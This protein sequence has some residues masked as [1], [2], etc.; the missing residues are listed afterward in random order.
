MITRGETKEKG[1]NIESNNKNMS[2]ENEQVDTSVEEIQIST[3][4]QINNLIGGLEESSKLFNTQVRNTLSE[5]RTIRRH[6]QKLEKSKKGGSRNTDP[7]KKKAPSGITKPTGISTELSTFLNLPPETLIPRTDVTKLISNYVKEN[8]LK[9]EEDG[10]RIDLEGEAGLK[11][12]ALLKPEV[13][14]SDPK[15]NGILTFFNLQKCLKGHFIKQETQIETE[16]EITPPEPPA[17]E[18]KTVSA[19]KKGQTRVRKARVAVSQT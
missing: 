8:N 11:L 2:D 10:R 9:N 18:E 1:K 14:L 13:H 16:T 5:L 12:K 3:A 6:V 4:E 7:N 15:Y 19:A 17:K